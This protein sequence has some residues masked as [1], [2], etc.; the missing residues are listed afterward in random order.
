MKFFGL[1]K[2]EICYGRFFN[3]F[4]VLEQVISSWV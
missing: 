2:Q 3:S 1:L 4:R